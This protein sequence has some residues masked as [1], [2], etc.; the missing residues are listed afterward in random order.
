[1]SDVHKAVRDRYGEA[2]GGSSCCGGGH[3]DREGSSSCCGGGTTEQVQQSTE[4]GYTIDELK[5]LPEGADLALGCGNPTALAA[6]KPGEVVVDLGSGG[7]IDC[8]LAASRVGTS[9][10]VIGVDM[11]P[12]MIERARDNAERAKAENVEFRLGEIEHLPI[13][14]ATADAVISNCV[15]NLAPDKSQVL[16]EA[17]RVL[18]PGGRVMISDLVLDAELRSDLRHNMALL[19]GCIAGAMQKREFIRALQRVGFTDV[20]IENETDYLS[21]DQLEPL[22]AEAG[23][24]EAD[25]GEIARSVRSVSVYAA[26]P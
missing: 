6:L 1:M 8:F 23:I 14:D 4:F 7:G 2:A 21:P 17:F 10:H 13:A 3:Y 20:H 22:A 12:E 15:I 9:G 26:R 24:S 19:T 11:T 5:T 16:K 25:A 18:R